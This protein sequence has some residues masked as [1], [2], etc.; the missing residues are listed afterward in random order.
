MA[1][2]NTPYGLRPYA[3][4]W[5]GPYNGAVSVYYVPAGNAT[6]LFLGDP[7]ALIGNSSDANGIPAVQIATAGASDYF[8]G[9]VVGVANNAGQAV[10]TVQWTTPVYIPVSTAAY[11]YVADDPNLVHAIQEDSVGGAL[12]TGAPGGGALLVA[13]TGSTVTGM[14]GWQLQSSS[15]GA[16]S[17]SQLR[18][19]RLLQETDNA[20]GVNAKWL[21]RNNLNTW[22][23]LASN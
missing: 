4:A 17:T 14:S 6:A 13:G 22:Y 1:N 21:V 11:V 19:M 23:G 7:V 9:P 12:A 3:Y 2:P 15:L 16:N 5:G 18:I 10:I 8:L 20:I